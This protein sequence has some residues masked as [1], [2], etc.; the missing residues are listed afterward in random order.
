MY[1]ASG[2]LK[3]A[4]PFSQGGL[5]MYCKSISCVL[6]LVLTSHFNSFVAED[7]VSL[8]LPTSLVGRGGFGDLLESELIPG[9]QRSVTLGGRK[10]ALDSVAL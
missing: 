7:F 5:R 2:L 8:G 4:Y 3:L 10:A 6:L 1:F 9:L